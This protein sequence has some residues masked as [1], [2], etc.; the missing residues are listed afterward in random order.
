MNTFMNTARFYKKIRILL[1]MPQI[2]QQ[3]GLKN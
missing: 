2:E 1:V 3:M